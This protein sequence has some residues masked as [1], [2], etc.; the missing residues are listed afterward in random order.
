MPELLEVEAYRRL[1]ASVLGLPIVAV[2]ADDAWFLKGGLTGPELVEAL[3]GGVVRRPIVGS[4]SCS[5]STSTTGGPWA[6]ASA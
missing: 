3:V 1:A 6:C 4:A 2:D 5:C